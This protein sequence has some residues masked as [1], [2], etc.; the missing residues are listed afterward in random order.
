MN[1]KQ[2]K[3]RWEILK[4]LVD[5]IGAVRIAE[6]GV[7]KGDTSLFLIKH[8]PN[9]EVMLL[10][11]PIIHHPFYNQAAF[12][13]STVFMK[14]KSEQA[15]NLIQDGSLDLVF[16]DGAHDYGNVRIDIQGWLPK[17]RKGGILCGHDYGQR[18]VVRNKRCLIEV[19]EA[20]DRYIG[21]ENI[22]VI[23]DINGLNSSREVD[24]NRAVWIYRVK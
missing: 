3:Q 20:V 22:E 7:K 13:K 4:D 2:P 9:I 19:T 5:E 10:I 14:M 1:K 18:T 21:R 17:V 6:I 15:F 24:K 11:D 23:A 8:C 12:L 16:I